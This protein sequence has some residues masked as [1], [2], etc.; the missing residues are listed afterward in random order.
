MKNNLLIILLSI[1]LF[2]CD[3]KG[4]QQKEIAKMEK[5]LLADPMHL[6]T[7]KAKQLI[8]KSQAYA[9]AYPKDTASARL[10]FKAADMARG[11]KDF[12]NAMKMWHEIQTNFADTKYAS[13]SLFLEG[14][15]FENDLQ[16]KEK[17]KQCYVK[18]INL[19]PK[20]DLSDDVDMALKNI[21]IPLEDLIK[22]FE[23]KNKSEIEAEAK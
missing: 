2:A 10:L 14:F 17:A 16:D 20:H 6:N 9:L 8:S 3:K 19:Y 4:S 23:A 11:I 22:T 7:E 13:E 1:S 15:T 12:P 21:D 5:E 18:F